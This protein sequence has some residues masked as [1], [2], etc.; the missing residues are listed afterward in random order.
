MA[1]SYRPNRYMAPSLRGERSI[2]AA[3]QQAR[4]NYAAISKK[5]SDAK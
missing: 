5:Q 1:S 2:D 4:E 3:E